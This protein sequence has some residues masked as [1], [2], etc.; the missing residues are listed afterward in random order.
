MFAIFPEIVQLAKKGD[1]ETLACLLRKYFGDR[2][3]YAPRLRVEPLLSNMGITLSREP[4]PFAA[5]VQVIDV[6]GQYH[7][8]LTLDA[9]LQDPWELNYTL[10]HLLGYFILSIQPLMARGELS[11]EAYQLQSGA[12]GRLLAPN[13]TKRSPTRSAES[14]AAD[15]FAKAL[16]LPLGMVKKAHEKL[17]SN[18]DLAGFF[19]VKAQLM[20][21]RLQELGLL[22]V[23]QSVEV[24]PPV[25][26]QTP[27][28]KTPNQETVRP[29][30]LEKVQKS[31][32]KLGY[33]KEEKRLNRGQDESGQGEGLKRLRQLAK[34]I[35]RSVDV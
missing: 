20:E 35:D 31:V 34:K 4:S 19:S 30:S 11:A 1:L 26:S 29:P 12:L 24:K 3:I 27:Q 14:T 25:A 6:K 21:L 17:T 23:P 2:Q 22:K 9:R 33:E 13:Y 7:V 16:L 5:R 18:S 10:A 15:D 28:A 32:A 8:S